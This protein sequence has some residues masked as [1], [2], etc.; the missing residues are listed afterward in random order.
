MS[1]T[2][3]KGCAGEHTRFVVDALPGA[4][5]LG[6]LR[7]LNDPVVDGKELPEQ[8]THFAWGAVSS[9]AQARGG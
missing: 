2:V 6:V 3:G 7:W 4:V 1:Q 8:F 5:G 9:T